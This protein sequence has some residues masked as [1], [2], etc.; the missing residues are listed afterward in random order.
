MMNKALVI[1]LGIMSLVATLTSSYTAMM[2]SQTTA[3]IQSLD[4]RMG[5]VE[6]LLMR[7]P[8]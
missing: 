5:R 3:V 1:A 6:S 7:E 4:N 2:Q 8:K